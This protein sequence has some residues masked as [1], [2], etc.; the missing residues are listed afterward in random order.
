MKATNFKYMLDFNQPSGTSR[1]ILTSKETW[2]LILK[3]ESNFGIGECGMLRGLS[4]DDRSDFEEKLNWVC[5]NINLGLNYLL[6]ELIN[7]PSIKFG[8]ETAFLDF[9]SETPFVLYPSFFT[10]GQDSIPINGLIWMGKKSFMKEQI[11]EKIKMGFKCIKIKIGAIDFQTEIDLIKFLRDEYSKDSIEIRVDA[12]GAFLPKDSL[13]KLKRLSEFDLHSIEQPIATGQSELMAELCEKSPIPIAL[14]EELIGIDDVTKRLN[15]LQ[16]VKP[17]YVVLKPS[18]LG[19]LASCQSWINLAKKES[20]SWW[21]TSALESNIGLNA[22][23][24]WTY[25]LEVS[26]PQGLG[27]GKLFSNNIYAPLEIE[28]GKLLYVPS[29]KWKLNF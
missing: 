4:I 11:K 17:K 2:F 26:C 13:E 23:A 6:E 3:D 12:N 8:L 29:K 10:K 28:S 7:F 27:T 18:L 1:G 5:D 16:T 15:L 25:N 20:I 22:I 21:I 24:Q 19:G 14:D 9:N